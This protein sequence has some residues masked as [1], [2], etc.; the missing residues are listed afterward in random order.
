MDLYA[1]ACDFEING[2]VKGIA[3]FGE[4]HINNTYLVTT[5]K[6]KYILQKINRIVFKDVDAVMS[7]ID[8]VTKFIAKQGKETMKVIPT[9]TKQLYL[10]K[11]YEY[12]RMTEFVKDTIC[13]QSAEGNMKL[14][15]SAGEAFGELHYLLKDLPIDK[16]KETIPNFHNTYKRYLNFLEASNVA[17]DEKLKEAKDEIGFIIAHRKDYSIIN[18]EMAKGNIKKYVIHNDTKLNNILFDKDTDEYRCVVDLDTLMP[19]SVLFD[20]GDAIRSFFT[21][22]NEDNP[23]LSLQK[24]DKIIFK[25]YM[26]DYLSKMKSELT[27]TEIELIPFSA[28]LMTIECGIRFLEDYLRGD[29]YFHTDYDKHN[30]V[31]AKT[32]IALAK[33]ILDSMDEL[34]DIVKELIEA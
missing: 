7:N 14:V 18:D 21:A 4:G 3:P 22:D 28:Y 1:L 19:G 10:Y 2:N 12:F 31:R 23:D 32:Q 11:D 5:D 6:S 34:K 9:K 13:H 27:K 24:V 16:V 33:N 25:T 20:I 15:A 8:V 30:L 17:D 26:K 29:I